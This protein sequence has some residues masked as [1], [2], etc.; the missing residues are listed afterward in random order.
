MLQPLTTDAQGRLLSPES[1]TLDYKQD[2]VTEKELRDL[3]AR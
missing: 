3:W 1:K 2:V